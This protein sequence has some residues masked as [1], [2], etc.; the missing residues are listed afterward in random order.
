MQELVDN[1]EQN[2]YKL[3][4]KTKTF[5]IPS[6]FQNLE[7]VNRDIYAKLISKGQ[8]RVKSD[9]CNDNFR[10]FIE[11]WV[12]G[13][14]PNIDYDN[15]YEYDQLSQEFDRMKQLIQIFKK[16]TVH[17]PLSDE[18]N[19]LNK[20]QRSK[21]DK[22]TEL[23]I[24]KQKYMKIIDILFQSGSNTSF[25]TS[26]PLRKH[27]ETA[28][29]CKEA[30]K[31]R[32]LIKK[33]AMI[34]N[35][36]FSLNEEENTAEVFKFI[37][38][39]KCVF[40]PR[41]I[42][43]ESREC[44]VTSIDDFA[45]EGCKKIKTVVFPQDSALETIGKRSFYR[46]SLES[47]I[48]PSHVTRIKKMAFAE[49]R[50]LA[51]VSFQKDSELQRIDKNAFSN[52]LIEGITI[53][54]KVTIIGKS[55][56]ENTKLK[57]VEIIG[58]LFKMK[59]PF[60]QSPLKQISI[61]SDIEIDQR[62]FLGLKYLEKIEIINKDKKNVILSENKLLLGKSDA[63]SN[64]YDVILFSPRDIESVT[65]P[66]NIT[67][68]EKY[69]FD[70]CEN[71]ESVIFEEDSKLQTIGF[72]SF[73]YTSIETIIIPKHVRRLDKYSFAYCKKL[74]SIEFDEDSE[75]LVIEECAFCLSSLEAIKVPSPVF[76]I[77]SSA[78]SG[79]EK[80]TKFEMCEKPQL[81]SIGSFIFSNTNLQKLQIPSS[82][83]NFEESWSFSFFYE[84]D[85]EIIPNDE[86]NIKLLTDGLIIGKTDLK[87]DIFNTLIFAKRSIQQ[88]VIPSFITR[89]SCDAFNRCNNLTK[90]EFQE[91]SQLEIIGN[92]AFN[93]CTIESIKIPSSVKIIE[94]EAF[95]ECNFLVNVE[96]EKNSQLEVIKNNAFSYTSIYSIAI[97]S[98]VI[99][100]E[101]E[102]FGSCE[103]LKKVTFE[104]DSHLESICQEAFSETSIE[105]III[106]SSVTKIESD[107]FYNC[108]N[109]RIV[110]IEEN[111]KLDSIRM[112]IF[113]ESPVDFVFMPTK[114][115]INTIN[116][117]E[118]INEYDEDYNDDDDDDDD[119]QYSDE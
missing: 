60:Y 81:K 12:K 54:P 88:V 52:C 62:L 1:Q 40:I 89:I 7:N 34:D 74:R 90:V 101:R 36:I 73:A 104:E 95:M 91:N 102:A 48:I 17:T 110:E 51:K 19:T 105:S 65:I 67:R 109:L 8:Y 3:I 44:V 92:S 116:P 115:T 79:C 56:F 86:V 38:R 82:I 64:D 71:L 30:S 39:S 15:L 113:I 85:V 87:K 114:N 96:F 31:I 118:E 93:S 26:S 28:C 106:P 108:A 27:I 84:A 18:I 75:L 103:R 43:Y 76:W 107:A 16:D 49:C 37:G 4:L 11:H 24:T 32:S 77:G 29:Q 69:A 100:I 42:K 23:L 45:F 72:Q 59:S 78:F 20:R 41:T 70:N 58:K 99:K 47:I 50:K 21:E 13:I 111:S 68:I 10:S 2:T 63:E 112:A 25:I 35:F 53:P 98:S 55:A 22:I 33:K 119:N 57:S 94:I 14:V 61:P 9:V 97:P 83:I 5:L 46:S 6:N 117:T 80:L 66:S